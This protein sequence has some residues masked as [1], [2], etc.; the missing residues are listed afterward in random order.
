ML[1]SQHFTR[2][3]I[4]AAEVRSFLSQ[5]SV[6]DRFVL[7]F[8][9]PLSSHPTQLHMWHGVVVA[10][11]DDRW[12][13]RAI[14]C[15]QFQETG[16]RV[17]FALPPDPKDVTVVD[18]FLDAASLRQP[19]STLMGSSFAT[20]SFMVPPE[21]SALEHVTPHS[22]TKVT[23]RSPTHTV[24]DGPDSEGMMQHNSATALIAAYSTDM[25]QALQRRLYPHRRIIVWVCL[26]EINC[27]DLVDNLDAEIVKFDSPTKALQFIAENI[28][29][30]LALVTSSLKNEFEL[31][32]I[33]GPALCDEV[34]K[35]RTSPQAQRGEG[36]WPLTIIVTKTLSMSDCIASCDIFVHA[37][38]ST[39]SICLTEISRRIAPPSVV[40]VN[41][42]LSSETRDYI[43]KELS[44]SI[45]QFDTTYRAYQFVSACP[46]NV[47]AVITEQCQHLQR[48]GHLTGVEL[49][50]RI[51]NLNLSRFQNPKLVLVGN[52][53]PD[54]RTFDLVI[55]SEIQKDQLEARFKEMLSDLSSKKQQRV[56]VPGAVVFGRGA[57]TILSPTYPSPFDVIID[58]ERMTFPNVEQFF[59]AAKHYGNAELFG[60]IR[61]APSIHA[62]LKLAW[63]SRIDPREWNS[64]RDDVM[65]YALSQKFSNRDLAK[66]LLLTRD[67]DIVHATLNSEDCYWGDGAE[68]GTHRGRNRMGEMLM[69]IRSMLQS[70]TG[71]LQLSASQHTDGKEF[72]LNAAAIDS[73]S[74][75]ASN[76]LWMKCPLQKIRHRSNSASSRGHR[77]HDSNVFEINKNEILGRGAYGR[78]YKAR[79]LFTNQIVAAKVA[80]VA[81][82]DEALRKEFQMLAKV[83]DNNVVKVLHAELP[84]N[85][86]ATIYMEYMSAGS[87][88]A[89]VQSFRLYETAIRAMIQQILEGLD[90]L[91]RRYEIVHCDLK[92]GNVLMS[93]QTV[94]ISDFGA[95][96]FVSTSNAPIAAQAAAAAAPLPPSLAHAASEQSRDSGNPTTQ[97]GNR[98]FH[99][100]PVTPPTARNPLRGAP[101]TAEYMSLDRMETSEAS[102]ADDVWAVGC[103]VVRLALGGPYQPW[104]QPGDT[105]TKLQPLTI[106]YRMQQGSQHPYIPEHLSPHAKQ[107]LARCFKLNPVE[108]ATAEQLCKD[109]WFSCGEAGMESFD[110][111][112]TAK[113]NATRESNEQFLATEDRTATM[114]V[115]MM[116][117]ESTDGGKGTDGLCR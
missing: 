42:D 64:L 20:T 15:A 99:E 116:D 23:D 105:V 73:V 62:A 98:S 45:H 68:G 47:A 101:G 24:G 110:D 80:T 30:M 67:S 6:G 65:F 88:E 107:F 4:S 40:C 76:I 29:S 70:T 35:L 32:G 38:K 44:F 84:D 89:Q 54:S 94:K 82:A 109:P 100:R 90:A 8:L 33:G 57:N 10:T 48:E 11:P 49:G 61:D 34:R 115:T 58:G 27:T 93:G 31:E 2:T 75:N 56:R 113:A 71:T 59:Q 18:I 21:A 5:L 108:R 91:H 22:H 111:Y 17:V 28:S 81:H 66:K 78:V 25:V 86:T 1:Q 16:H 19:Q 9:E 106:C 14:R 41:V 96:A 55:G 74:G 63:K 117:V 79:D 26:P 12:K 52:D 97:A 60:S 46:W 77:G 7:L 53:S 39:D 103:I 92:A 85:G 13:K 95:S 102:F 69:A 112:R 36:G 83:D 3:N 50:H 37:L 51:K 72:E 114:R 104:W 87:L 43:E